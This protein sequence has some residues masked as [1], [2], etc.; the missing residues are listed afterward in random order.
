M[1]Y[2]QE[3]I[4]K[5]EEKYLPVIN[6]FQ[7]F[8][9]CE[10]INMYNDKKNDKANVTLEIKKYLQ[11]LDEFYT[12]VSPVVKPIAVYPTFKSKTKKSKTKKSKTKK[13]K[14]KKSKAKK[15]K[16]KKSKA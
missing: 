4:Q 3:D 5:I 15:S 13:S 6:E 10:Y 14:A 16:A 8:V 9:L 11:S 1:A 2:R 12:K 7:K